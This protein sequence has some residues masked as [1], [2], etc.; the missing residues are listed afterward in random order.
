VCA[1]V[2]GYAAASEQSFFY[3]G[4]HVQVTKARSDPVIAGLLPVWPP[5]RVLAL[6][7][8]PRFGH[9]QT[10]AWVWSLLCSLETS[11]LQWP[12]HLVVFSPSKYRHGI[13]HTALGRY[14]ENT[15]YLARA[16]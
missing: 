7:T 3:P 8:V 9:I 1:A 6:F 12:F 16:L 5:L 15:A 11:A 14:D 2:F 13:T 4:V 10:C